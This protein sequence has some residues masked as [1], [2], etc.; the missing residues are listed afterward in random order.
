MFIFLGFAVLTLVVL[1]RYARYHLRRHSSELEIDDLRALGVQHDVHSAFMKLVNDDGAGQWPPKSNHE[2]WPLQLR[3]YKEIYATMSPL[4]ATSNPS[5]DDELNK[6]RCLEFRSRMQA[7]LTDRIDINAVESALG[8]VAAGDWDSFPR[9]SYNGFYSC[10][11]CL[12]HAYRW[13]TNPVV[14]IAQNEK[15]IFFPFELDMPWSYL[16][17]RFD[18]T[19]PSGN[20]MSNVVCNFDS[21]GRLAYLVNEG[22]PEIVVKTELAWCRLFY[23]SES[24][25]TPVYCAII[26]AIISF[27][28]GDKASSLAYIETALNYLRKLLQ[29]LYEK[30]NDPHVARSVWVRHVSGIHSWGATVK[31][32]KSSIEYGG[33]SGSQILTFLA[34]DAFL[35][36]A[37]YQS[38]GEMKMHISKNMREVCATIRKHSFRGKLSERPEDAAISEALDRITKQMRTFRVVHKARAVRYLSAPAPER[39]P[40]TAALSV[41]KCSEEKTPG[42]DLYEPVN[43]ILTKRLNETI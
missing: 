18:I 19:S 37:P 40:M 3:P 33:L 14:R 11:A 36:L 9:D 35:G 1:L 15:Q 28:Q 30:M 8:T 41:L 4:L 42:K 34:V 38:D 43:T 12:R 2:E 21:H 24:M 7:L 25:G 13:A 29:N 39:V 10:I 22:M 26:Q 31:S 6:E 16:Q 5:T 23:D 20:I 27:E 17:Q 32:D